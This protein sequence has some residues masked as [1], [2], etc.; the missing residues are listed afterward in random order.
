MKGG[1]TSGVVY[2]QAILELAEEYR[3]RSVGGGSVGA[4][5]SALAAAGELN[6]EG[7]G[8]EAVERA[9]RTPLEREDFLLDLFRPTEVARPLM[10]TLIDLARIRDGA[11]RKG[12]SVWAAVL[13]GLAPTLLRRNPRTFLLGA[14]AGAAL[15][16]ALVH[17]LAEAFDSALG[18]ASIYTAMLVVGL[19]CALVLS[20]LW[21][22]A[23][24][25][26]ILLKKVP[27]ARNFYGMCTG[28]GDHPPGRLPPLTDWLSPVLDE[29]SGIG[30]GPLLFRHLE[31]KK[32]PGEDRGISLEVMTTNLNHNEPYLFPREPDTFV[33]KESEMR[34]FFPG[35][36]VD[37]MV[38]EAPTP[39]VRLPEGFY[40]LPRR[41]AMPV[42][43]PVR[44]AISFPILLCAV[45][46]YTV[47]P[48]ILAGY[49]ESP[50]PLDEKEHL[51][52]NWFSDGGICSNFPIHSFDAWLPEHPT[53][54]INLTSLSPGRE[55]S[56][57]SAM[58]VGEA[59]DGTTA[60]DDRSRAKVRLP[61]PDEPDH[62]EWSGFG[63]LVGFARAIFYSA[64]NYRDNMQSRLPSYQERV[65]QIRLEAGEGGL[66][67]AMDE[68]T[69]ADLTKRGEEAGE[70]LKTFRFD[71]HRWVRLRVLMNQLEEQLEGAEGALVSILREG[72]IERQLDGEFPH[73][74][75][76]ADRVEAGRKTLEALRE[77][78][79]R[80]E[81]E[82]ASVSPSVPP[83]G[84]HVFPPVAGEELEPTLR[85]TPDV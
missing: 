2:P 72:L 23:V 38:R 42:I 7:G 77:L 84:P 62:P 48:K 66:N 36:V 69:I 44:M 78:T 51:Q 52:V 45:P 40:L 59:A 49:E 55:R 35:Y 79:R 25:L 29:I 12:R 54:G 13:R 74:I 26:V 39:K 75:R 43:V 57:F 70:L 71:H 60:S 81:E 63:G 64:Q 11:R 30:S 53:F 56:A 33:F 32:R 76:D 19:V 41:D 73:P 18:A 14:I 5:A 1:I 47:D 8:F 20:V 15:G 17:V 6:R 83:Q 85:V 58:D 80:I 61:R 37:Y 31:A 22:A 16:I 4:I 9:Q 46:L 82:H 65:V 21:T 50:F 24:L 68:E 28:R 3:F 67:L 34:R 27:S 10:E